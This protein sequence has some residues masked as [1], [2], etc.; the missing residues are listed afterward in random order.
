MNAHSLN[1]DIDQGRANF[2]LLKEKQIIEDQMVKEFNERSRYD[3]YF[4]E[5]INHLLAGQITEATNNITYI[6][7]QVEGEET[8]SSTFDNAI[9]DTR[10]IEHLINYITP[11]QPVLSTAIL[12]FVSR[13]CYCSS[14]IVDL[15]C[16]TGLLDHFLNPIRVEGYP[17]ACIAVSIKIAASIAADSQESAE[18]IRNSGIIE[19]LPTLLQSHNP[20]LYEVSLFFITE[21][22][23]NAKLNESFELFAGTILELL[24]QP[25]ID[26]MFGDKETDHAR[27]C[28][29]KFLVLLCHYAQSRDAVQFIVS[30][31]NRL[32]HIKTLA[33]I[34]TY[35][36]PDKD[37]RFTQL[38]TAEELFVNASQEA[39][40]AFLDVMPLDFLADAINDSD[41][42][43]LMK[44]M[45][46]FLEIFRAS[47]AVAVQVLTKEFLANLMRRKDEES[48]VVQL[49]ISSFMANS[50]LLV[51]MNY[52]LENFLDEEILEFIGEGAKSYA[53]PDEDNSYY[54]L[55]LR[56]LQR[57]P[58][59]TE[60][61]GDFIEELIEY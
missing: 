53:T 28:R 17:I 6:C 26:F 58:T 47:E 46:I 51:Q 18:L 16:E 60:E 11:E 50:I 61:V 39:I 56:K 13:S 7:K 29:T 25:S 49:S 40:L 5:T 48:A 3:D 55:A 34:L 21:Y 31:E 12:D 14:N 30:H 1:S 23:R 37:D 8:Y 45:G 52:C 59:I 54:F 42:T 22:L 20:L 10:F 32:E 41:A 44:A 24:S 35:E 19:L 43:F 38:R 57:I 2:G 4:L 9:L 36:F 27:N 15:I 33:F